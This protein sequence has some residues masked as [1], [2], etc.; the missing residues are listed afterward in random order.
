MKLKFNLKWLLLLIAVSAVVAW[1]F[2]KA[3]MTVA[4]VKIISNQLEMNDQGTIDG[5]LQCRLAEA[6]DYSYEYVDFVCDVYHVDHNRLLQLKKG[7]RTR[8]EYR[9]KPLWPLVKRGDPYRIFLNQHL[10]IPSEEILG[11]V[12]I[13]GTGRQEDWMEIRI[14]GGESP[15]KS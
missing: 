8:I 11:A 15:D 14:R 4:H 9:R 1:W 12:R 7:D 5:D 13:Q 3:G 2:S 10:G 6:T